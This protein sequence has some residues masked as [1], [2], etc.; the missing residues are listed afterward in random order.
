MDDDPSVGAT[1]QAGLCD[2]FVVDVAT[3][4]E[5]GLRAIS[6]TGYDALVL[7]LGLP[8]L[9]GLEVLRLL[10]ADPRSAL[11]PILL[12]TG[13]TDGAIHTEATLA[14][15]DDCVVKPSDP[16]TIET[17]LLAVLEGRSAA[18]HSNVL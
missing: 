17:R 7:D 4:A 12:F 14:G 6:L 9:P 8:D 13:A 11:L 1:L 18:A 5:D 2:S 15:A 16:Q 3:R 10:R